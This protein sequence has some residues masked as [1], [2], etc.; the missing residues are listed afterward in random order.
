VNLAQLIDPE[1]VQSGAHRRPPAARPPPLAVEPDEI[2]AEPVKRGRRRAA[3]RRV[4]D[5]LAELGEA[6]M[7]EILAH[8]GGN[9]EALCVLLIAMSRRSEVVRTGTRRSYRYSLP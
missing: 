8:I 5:A 4:L 1:F 6:S 7:G 2:D 9:R 3:S